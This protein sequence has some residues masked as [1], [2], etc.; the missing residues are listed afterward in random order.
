PYWIH[1]QAGSAGPST[2]QAAAAAFDLVQHRLVIFGGENGATPLDDAW[3]LSSAAVFVT[4]TLT[5]TPSPSVTCTPSPVA[6]PV[7]P[8]AGGTLGYWPMTEGAGNTIADVCGGHNGNWSQG[9]A[10]AADGGGSYLQFSPG[11]GQRIRIDDSVL[12]T[13]TSTTVELRVEAG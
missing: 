4:P 3:A 7:D 2:R 11:D 8:C 1:L 5:P 6:P 12:S 9:V 13:N 10:W